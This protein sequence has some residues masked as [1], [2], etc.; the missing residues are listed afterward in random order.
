MLDR[1]ECIFSFSTSAKRK[2]CKQRHSLKLGKK[3]RESFKRNYYITSP[4]VI[5]K[6]IIIIILVLNNLASFSKHLKSICRGFEWYVVN[7]VFLWKRTLESVFMARSSLPGLGNV[8]N[9]AGNLFPKGPAHIPPSSLEDETRNGHQNAKRNP[10]RNHETIVLG[11]F[12]FQNLK[13]DLE[14]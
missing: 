9:L 14:W 7:S 3:R 12:S 6:A 10:N 13:R 2:Q 5:I 11:L 1:L 8:N 4:R